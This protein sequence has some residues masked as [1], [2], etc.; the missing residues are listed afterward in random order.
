MIDRTLQNNPSEAK[1][2][3]LELKLLARSKE[4]IDIKSNIDT[5]K[6]WGDY[7]IFSNNTN[8]E[9][10]LY[11]DKLEK[12]PTT[13]S[14]GNSFYVSSAMKNNY[15]EVMSDS[16]YLNIEKI[17]N[18][19]K[20]IQKF[21]FKK[22]P[23]LK[24]MSSGNEYIYTPTTTPF[25]DLKKNMMIMDDGLYILM[26][27]RKNSLFRSFTTQNEQGITLAPKDWQVNDM[28]KFKD[29]SP[30]LD[31]KITKIL[32]QKDE[33]RDLNDKYSA[34]LT[35][36]GLNIVP[37]DDIGGKLEFSEKLPSIR[38][39]VS[40]DPSNKNIIYFCQEATPKDIVRLDISGDSS[41]WKSEYAPLSKEY[42]EIKNLQL[43]PTGTFFLFYSEDNLIM[44]TKDTFE[45]V[46]VMPGI[47]NVNF[48]SQGRIR[49]VD[50]D[51]HLVLYSVDYDSLSGALAKRKADKLGKG[52]N[53]K[54]IFSKKT[55][56]TQSY[57]K[58]T[59][60]N[61]EP[62]K[63]EWEAEILP[64]ITGVNT[65]AEVIELRTSL[66][67]LRTMLRSQNLNSDQI[68]FITD[69][70]GQAISIKEKEYAGAEA[71]K[72]ITDIEA[73]LAG[74]ISINI[75]SELRTLLDK[76]KP[77]EG[78][79]ELPDREKI[80]A[81]AEQVNKLAI[82]IFSREGN[83]VIEDLK[84][85]IKE[86]KKQLEGLTDKNEFDVWMD[87]TLP[88]LKENLG[89]L[90]KDCP[91]ESFDTANT[92]L[93][94]RTNLVN[95]ADEYQ[96]KF[97]LQYA[98]VD[99]EGFKIKN[100]FIQKLQADKDALI[101]RLKM[102]QF[103]SREE[104]EQ[105]INTS[106]AKRVFD[107]EIKDLKKT[108]LG[109][110]KELERGLNGDLANIYG[111]IER[112]DTEI[113]AET[114][115][116][117]IAFGGVSFPK[118]EGKIKVKHDTKV[119]VTFVI[120]PTSKGPGIEP[121]DFYGNVQLI[122]TNTKG[123]KSSVRLYEKMENE[124]EWRLGLLNYRG[125]AVPP[126]YVNATDFQSIKKDF[127]R[128]ENGELKTMDKEFRRDLST[129][130]SLR[131][132]I[133]KRDPERD[134]L[135]QEDYKKKLKEYSKFCTDNHIL[136]FRR[137]SDVKEINTIDLNGKGY[138]PKW[139][140]H[141]VED[142]VAEKY[143]EQMAKHFKMQSDLQEGVLNLYGHA[144]TG[145]DVLL[146]MFASK[147]KANRPY[148]STDCSKWTTEYEL[149]EDVI[150]E[151]K[152]GAT[153][154]VRVPS[155]ILSG[156]TTPGALVYLNEFNAMPEQAQIFLHA[157]FDEKRA[158]T[159]K[160]SSGKLVKADP[161]VLLACSMNP[162]YPGTFDPQF[163]TKSRMVSIE[164][165]YPPLRRKSIDSEPKGKEDPYSASEA[166]RIARGV[167]S[168]VDYTF[169]SNMSKNDFVKIWDKNVNGI[170][171]DAPNITKSQEFDLYTIRALIQF[172]DRL[173]TDF[174]KNFNK[175]TDKKDALPV[176]QPLTLREM[177]R[178]AYALSK[179]SDSDKLTKDSDDVARELIK[180]Y[181]LSN[182]FKT[183]DK[184][185]IENALKLMHSKNR[186]T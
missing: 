81:L 177:R 150:L 121:K 132:A 112:K 165:D 145:K 94:A 35:D 53:I 183:D 51:G 115:Q 16:N 61:L 13:L 49:G 144:G 147:E 57:D 179:M 90:L 70:I 140:N 7:T 163:A 98:K 127:V 71:T 103:N 73:K 85:V 99:E 50:K 45:E 34:L 135:W 12:I 66:I 134:V 128:W 54:D 41:T 69:G 178:S 52:I 131:L 44:T 36:V 142:P 173:R 117:M 101:D 107:A 176:F 65:M 164:V 87:F 162:N 3:E 38:D 166:L 151:A 141:W 47:T 106:E 18:L 119:D 63:Q 15:P 8:E 113:N 20:L 161:S 172:A 79:L 32:D 110:A 156:I 185:K 148:F 9:I 184:N 46:K 27:D 77:F 21:L 25:S 102:K 11:N 74:S 116:Q 60:E 149:A 158:M 80:R 43:D 122:V 68:S 114:G 22:Y 6:P 97:V 67:T 168:L 124:D 100:I 152:D 154:T 58:A 1:L 83:K 59:V 170:N 5:I 175:T 125:D 48:D 89:M 160:T 137:V 159:L 29:L 24:G 95:M 139:Q 92:I 153:Q 169:E 108:N 55:K 2:P 126:S 133:G 17:K 130:Y 14:R 181:F 180:E 40:V 171:N 82:E 155:S 56:E 167:E 138:V 76:I 96:K 10:S 91:M 4:R 146:K 33:V 174:K 104:A 143:L 93:Q 26:I 39:N 62:L 88:H 109:A 28:T 129:L 120:D 86:T 105:Y 186:I 75:I 31:E 111:S 19:P 157:L 182:I 23:T 123:D 37:K 64:K 30:E 136:L 78:I 42:K 118:F 84:M 72:L